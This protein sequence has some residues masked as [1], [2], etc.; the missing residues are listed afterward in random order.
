MVLLLT[1]PLLAVACRI[2]RRWLEKPEEDSSGDSPSH[3]RF[4]LADLLWLTLIV[5]MGMVLLDLRKV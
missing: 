2:A 3:L 1:V 5:G 4:S